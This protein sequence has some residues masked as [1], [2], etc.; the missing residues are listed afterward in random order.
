MYTVYVTLGGGD[1]ISRCVPF[2]ND[3]TLARGRAAAERAVGYLAVVIYTIDPP[4]LVGGLTDFEFR[5]AREAF[6]QV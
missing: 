3:A 2:Y 5:R 4:P 6:D 1:E